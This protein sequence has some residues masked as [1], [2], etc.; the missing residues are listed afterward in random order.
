MQKEYSTYRESTRGK[1]K[2]KKVETISKA[3]KN[4]GVALAEKQAQAS[5]LAAKG[6]LA[7]QWRD[8]HALPAS[9]RPARLLTPLW[10][11]DITDL[12]AVVMRAGR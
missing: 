2:H 7:M 1:V 10:P 4:K 12:R 5:R 6:G 9:P 8:A 11:Y 3:R